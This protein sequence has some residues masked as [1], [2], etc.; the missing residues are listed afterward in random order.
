MSLENAETHGIKQRYWCKPIQNTHK[1]EWSW[2]DSNLKTYNIIRNNK[3][4]LTTRLVLPEYVTTHV[5]DSH[6]TLSSRTLSY[7]RHLDET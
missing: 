6:I 5:R 2:R 1:Y 4:M 7:M 3:S